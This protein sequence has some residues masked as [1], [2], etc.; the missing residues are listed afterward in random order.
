MKK[1]ESNKTTQFQ[2]STQDQVTQSDVHNVCSAPECAGM[3]FIRFLTFFFSCFYRKRLPF[4]STPSYP[5]SLKERREQLHMNDT[6]RTNLPLSPQ[7]M[8][9][10]ESQLPDFPLAQ[11]SGNASHPRC[12]TFECVSFALIAFTRA[13]VLVICSVSSPIRNRKFKHISVITRAST[14]RRSRVMCTEIFTFVHKFRLC[15]FPGATVHRLHRGRHVQ[16]NP[17]HS[18]L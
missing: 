5:T 15:H 10:H 4:P 14:T 1:W 9:A 16:L 17:S 11:P 13:F 12:A 8:S 3:L 7:G 2:I 18:R 6:S